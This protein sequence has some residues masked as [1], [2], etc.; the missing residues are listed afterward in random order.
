MRILLAFILLTASTVFSF[1]EELHLGVGRDQIRITS[2]FNGTDLTIFGSVEGG[3]PSIAI[4]NGYDLVV[5]LEGPQEP[6]NVRLKERVLGIWVNT[7]G[8]VVSSAPGS[9]SLSTTRPF[10]EIAPDVTFRGL[11]IGLQAVPVDFVETSVEGFDDAFIRLK[12]ESG[13]YVENIGAVTFLSPVL[14]NARV[15]IPAN[16]PLG[17]HTVRGYLFRDGSLLGTASTKM[18]V[19]K[20]GFE[21]FTYESAQNHGLLYG[22]VTVIVAMFAGW[23]A[24]VIFR[25]K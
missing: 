25:K 24:S 16:V 8:R 5:V 9:Y 17:E 11:G 3:K 6:A 10:D 4:D 1:A 22:I 2:S 15:A 20:D 19:I 7:Q 18:R 21:A 23:L 14:F 13:L 12:V